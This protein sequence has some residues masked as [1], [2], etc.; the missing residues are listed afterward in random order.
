MPVDP[1]TPEAA[2]LP[3]DMYSKGALEA[4]RLVKVMAM[5]SGGKLGY[6]G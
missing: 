6:N 2:G 1:L 3:W 4:W 5:G